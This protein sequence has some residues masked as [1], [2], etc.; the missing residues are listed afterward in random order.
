M[1]RIIPSTKTAPRNLRVYGLEYVADEE[2]EA[3]EDIELS[4]RAK[5]CAV[6]DAIA[7]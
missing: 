2:C 3:E 6:K 1:T 4:T 5:R 7:P